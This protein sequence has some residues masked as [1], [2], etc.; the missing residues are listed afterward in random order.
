MTETTNMSQDFTD[1][2]DRDDLSLNLSGAETSRNEEEED[3]TWEKLA[4]RA[5]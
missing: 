2:S 3:W 5:K 4:G 1:T